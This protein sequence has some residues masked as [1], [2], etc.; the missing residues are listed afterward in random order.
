[1]SE[2]LPQLEADDEWL[3]IGDGSQHEARKIVENRDPHIKYSEFGP[4]RCW[5]HEQRNFAIKKAKG[6]HLW[7]VDDDD[8]VLPWALEAIRKRAC[9]YPGRPLLFKSIWTNLRIAW[10]E[11]EV[12][13]GNVGTNMVVAPNLPSRIGTWGARWEGDYDFI[14]STVALYPEG[15]KSVAWCYDILTIYGCGNETPEETGKI[16]KWKF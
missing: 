16:G 14:S 13:I 2:L 4:T 8:R 5:G 12:K 1:M 9:E 10:M 7:F 6:T 3:V 15:G 11:R